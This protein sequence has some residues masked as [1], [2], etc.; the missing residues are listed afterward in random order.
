MLLVPLKIFFYENELCITQY[1]DKSK[2]MILYLK[3]HVLTVHTFHN[4]C[5]NGMFLTSFL[6]MNG[7]LSCRWK[8]FDHKFLSNI[9]IHQ[10]LTFRCKRFP[11][12][13]FILSSTYIF[14]FYRTKA[15]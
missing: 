14:W 13:V 3:V 6:I 7:L 4:I 11:S 12:L 10:E 8:L 1:K 15:L 9:L 5:I 2:F